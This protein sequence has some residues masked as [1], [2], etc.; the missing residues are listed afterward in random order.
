MLASRAH[1][2]QFRK[3]GTSQLSHCLQVALS[4]VDLGLDESTIAAGLLHES[5]QQNGGLRS[6][7]EEFMSSEV[8][9]MVDRVTTISEIRSVT[10]HGI[11]WTVIG[12]IVFVFDSVELMSHN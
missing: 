4:L 10:S 1:A 5:L 6:Q 7:L 3:D 2:G 8:V 12:S 11:R 9:Q